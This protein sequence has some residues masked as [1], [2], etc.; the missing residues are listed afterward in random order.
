[1]NEIFFITKVFTGYRNDV[2][3]ITKEAPGLLIHVMLTQ[4]LL[5]FYFNG[6]RF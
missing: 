6:G 3:F 1:M 4:H 5:T 2:F